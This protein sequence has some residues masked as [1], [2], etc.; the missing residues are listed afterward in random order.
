M[1]Q[2]PPSDT[3]RRL[4]QAFGKRLAHLRVERGLSQKAI[5]RHLGTRHDLVSKYERGL[6]APKLSTLLRLRSLFSVTLDHLLA[7]ASQSEI[8]DPRLLKW[9]RAA[10][11]LSPDHRGF[12]ANALESMVRAA[13]A[14]DE[15]EKAAA[16]GN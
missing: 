3:D 2:R 11:A 12:I 6:H 8:T 13:Q 10:N 7:G 14:A 1:A 4:L 5:A 16:G 15:R 9:A